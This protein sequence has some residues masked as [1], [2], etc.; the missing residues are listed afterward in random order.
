MRRIEFLPIGV[1]NPALR[2]PRHNQGQWYSLLYGN[3]KKIGANVGKL[4]QYESPLAFS[5]EERI[6][7]DRESLGNLSGLWLLVN[8]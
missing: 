4:D 3:G 2:R 7:M 5:S 1:S 8:A 6:V